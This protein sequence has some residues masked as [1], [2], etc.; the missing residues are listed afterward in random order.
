MCDNVCFHY[1]QMTRQLVWVQL[2]WFSMDLTLSYRSWLTNCSRWVN[3]MYVWNSG[4]AMWAASCELRPVSCDLRPARWWT[5]SWDLRP[6]YRGSSNLVIQTKP[7]SSCMFCTSGVFPARDTKTSMA[8]C[9]KCSAVVG[10]NARFCSECGLKVWKSLSP[11]ELHPAPCE[12]RPRN[13][14]AYHRQPSGRSSHVRTGIPYVWAYTTG[15][16]YIKNKNC[17]RLSP[18]LVV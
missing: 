2:M 14:I 13:S 16:F 11:C 12:L 10:N 6:A 18:V 9:T 4:S 15:G 5:A 3:Y 17:S 1:C 7:S 8:N